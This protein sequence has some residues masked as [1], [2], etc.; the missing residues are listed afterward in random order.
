M[1]AIA[2]AD[3]SSE[4]NT[5]ARKKAGSLSNA[6]ALIFIILQGLLIVGAL[7][8]IATDDYSF[9]QVFFENMAGIAAGLLRFDVMLQIAVQLVGF[10]L[11]GIGALILGRIIWLRHGNTDGKP[12]TRIAFV[13]I[14]IN[15]ILYIADPHFIR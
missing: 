9:L 6:I 10:N 5:Q 12:I 2:Q 13:V 8:N 7:C 14:I 3:K 4:Q 1:E 15:T 11:L